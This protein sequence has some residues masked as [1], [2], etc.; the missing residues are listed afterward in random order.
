MIVIKKHYPIDEITINHKD[1]HSNLF[2]L[3]NRNIVHV[4]DTMI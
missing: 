1:L 4:C 2:F 3:E